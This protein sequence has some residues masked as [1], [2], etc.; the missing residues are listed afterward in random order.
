MF[1]HKKINSQVGP[2]HVVSTG[3]KLAAIV[4]DNA[5]T[6]FLEREGWELSAG[7]DE[8]IQQTET[9]LEEYFS[10][11]RKQFDIPLHF[12][13]SEFQLQT[14]QS[15]LKIPFGKTFSYGEQAKTLNR[16][17]AVRAV[18]TANG[19]NKICIIVPCHRVIGKNGSLTGF[20]GGIEIK[21]Q[22]LR[23]ESCGSLT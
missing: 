8:I 7:T 5:W 22:L 13:G 1:I 17:D 4:F 10:G 20:S 15:L 16:P 2:L 3:V 9:Q 12:S 18:G 6:D 14:W 11:E 19:K 23:L 21:K